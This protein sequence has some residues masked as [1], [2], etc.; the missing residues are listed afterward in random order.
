MN[1]A[2]RMMAMNRA[3]G[4]MGESRNE[5]GDMRYESGRYEGGNMRYEGGRYEGRGG[6]R[7]ESGRYEGGGQLEGRGYARMDPE[8]EE[9]E[10][11]QN[12]NDGD[13]GDTSRRIRKANGEEWPRESERRMGTYPQ[14]RRME[15][16]MNTIGFGGKVDM[17]PFPKMG[18]SRMDN[19][20]FDKR[21]AEEWVEGM[22]N[23]DGSH[24]EH[25][26]IE[27]TEEIRL[28][29]GVQCD[30]IE[31]WAA[32]NAAYSDLGK[33]AQKHHLGTDFWV[34]YVKAFWFE[35]ADAGPKKLERY[36]ECFGRK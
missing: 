20:R 24:G 34:D 35:D 19:Q 21:T 13:R 28:Q 7:Y 23:A 4:S 26:S 36:H 25:W 31:F 30:P 18:H 33:M 32:M 22:E 9:R 3:R 8:R 5:G 2:M 16:R 6:M 14:E 11:R 15:A 12:Y 10:Y 1:N 17:V 29:K 27:K